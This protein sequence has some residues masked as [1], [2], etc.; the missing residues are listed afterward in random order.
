MNARLKL[1]S[2]GILLC[3]ALGLT[4]F[5]AVQTV[6]AFQRFQQEHKLAVT[7]DVSTIRSWMTVPFIA[8]FYNVPESY[9]D[10]SLHI[11]NDRAVHHLP[12]R[13]L[14]DR[15]KRP[16]DSLIH[17]IQHAIL[18]YRKHRTRAGASPVPTLLRSRSRSA[19]RVGA[20][21]APVPA[22]TSAAREKA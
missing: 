7:G 8:H 20:G 15:F 9:L 17:D 21:L 10:Q 2:T 5:C 22:S 13:E 1:V 16:L 3:L 4:V 6:Q 11:T 19:Y 18:N 14:A 12:L